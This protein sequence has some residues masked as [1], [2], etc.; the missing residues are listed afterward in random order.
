MRPVTVTVFIMLLEGIFPLVKLVTVV[1]IESAPLFSLFGKLAAVR[2]R[3]GAGA[4]LFLGPQLVIIVILPGLLLVLPIFVPVLRVQV[5]SKLFA[6][7]LVTSVLTVAVI[8]ILVRFVIIIVVVIVK[9]IVMK[10]KLE[11]TGQDPTK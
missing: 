5:F 3:P 8:V 6:Q 10:V 2:G 7:R 4:G 1:R 9:I 11:I